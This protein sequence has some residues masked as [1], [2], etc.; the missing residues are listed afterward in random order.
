MATAL[1]CPFANFE[2]AS[3]SLIGWRS[4]SASPC[5]QAANDAGEIG[6]EA[7]ATD[8]AQPVFSPLDMSVIGIG[9][10]DRLSFVK[11]GSRLAKLQRFLFGIE[12]PL[13]FADRRL[14][15]LRRLALASRRRGRS[16]ADEAALALQAGVTP[17]QI[18]HLRPSR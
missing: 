8:M 2:A 9:K 4:R 18:R 14:E 16:F 11:P 17:A 10:R 12:A 7:A 1:P 13:P 3:L 15:A 6:T 5:P